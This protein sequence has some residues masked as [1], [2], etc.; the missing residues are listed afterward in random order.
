MT[1]PVICFPHVSTRELTESSRLT[2]ITVPAATMFAA[3][4]G[5]VL[6]VPGYDL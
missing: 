4:A 5:G 6:V 1:F 2:G 3:G